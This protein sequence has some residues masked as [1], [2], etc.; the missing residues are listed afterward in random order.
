MA[1]QLLDYDSS[2]HF[3]DNEA[4]DDLLK[5]AIELN[6]A[7]YI[8]HA[9]GIIARAHGMTKVAGETGLKRQAL[10]RALEKDGNPTL[11]T[12]L[13]VMQALDLKLSITRAENPQAEPAIV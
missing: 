6:D 1:I 4:Q 11:D 10:Y 5:D 13:K 8:A 12:L 7:G 3:T 2:E 9:I